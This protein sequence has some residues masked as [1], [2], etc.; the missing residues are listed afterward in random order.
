MRSCVLFAFTLVSATAD[1]LTCTIT[2]RQGNVVSTDCVDPGGRW[3]VNGDA[4]APVFVSLQSWGAHGS[5]GLAIFQLVS[6]LDYIVH[7]RIQASES[8]SQTFV[9]N[10]QPAGTHGYLRYG[11]TPDPGDYGGYCQGGTPVNSPCGGGISIS[12]STPACVAEGPAIWPF[13]VACRIPFTYGEPFALSASAS[14]IQESSLQLS[15][16]GL[17]S[18]THYRY[19]GL[20]ASLL[21]IVVQSE[22]ANTE[23]PEPASALLISMI[24]P[25]IAVHRRFRRVWDRES[26]S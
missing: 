23:A 25:A 10:D 24:L 4:I 12:W 1:E 3:R 19:E 14:V 2:D 26:R 22:V 11:L 18:T 13:P 17:F 16:A 15:S 9:L 6:G 7:A 20:S 21:G 8:I 5:S